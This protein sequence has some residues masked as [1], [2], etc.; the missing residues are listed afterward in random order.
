[1]IY[2]GGAF[3]AAAVVACEPIA[4]NNAQQAANARAIRPPDQDHDQ[5]DNL[6]HGE[7]LTVNGCKRRN[8]FDHESKI[9]AFRSA[10]DPRPINQP[11]GQPAFNLITAP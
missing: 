10:S 9:G 4:R 2:R 11:L 1:M 6:D 8:T 5:Q 3:P 7:A